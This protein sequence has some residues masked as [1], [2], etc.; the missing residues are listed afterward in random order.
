MTSKH[1]FRG[2]SIAVSAD[3]SVDEQRYLYQKTREFKEAWTHGG[4][5]SPF[6]IEDPQLSV[7]LMFFEDSTRTKES[8]RNAAQFHNVAVNIFDAKNSSIT[9]SES[10]VDTIKMLFG[11]SQRSIFILRT[12]MEGVCRALQEELGRYAE[13]IGREA[14]VFINGGD[15]RHEHP[16]QEYLDEFTFLE[17]RQWDDSHIHLALIGDLLHGRT[18]HSKVDGLKAF[19]EVK[20]DLVAPLELALP[21]YYEKRMKANGFEVEKYESLDKYMAS[22]KLSDCWYF[23]RLQLERMGE[24]ILKKEFQLRKAVTFDQKWTKL[25]QDGTRF[26]H[27]LPRHRE[28]SV[29][30][31]FLDR[32]PLNGWDGQSINGYFTRTIELAICA[33]WLGSDFSGRGLPEETRDESFIHEEPVTRITQVQ[34]RFKVG[35]KPVD[36]GVVIDHIAKGYSPEEIWHRIDKI[37][38]ILNLNCGS[39][40]GVF[41]SEQSDK[42]FKGIISLPDVMRIEKYD[43]KKLAA[44][45]PGCTVNIISKQSVKEKYRL[46]MPPQIFKF[47]EISCKNPECVTFPAA[48]QHVPPFFYNSGEK[49]FTCR[50]CGKDHEYREIWDI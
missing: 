44:V 43:L 47:E 46:S 20:V 18:V 50:Y 30:P 4:D 15:G 11:Y 6:R 5:L 29:I 39:S 31:T 10:I 32:T 49:I 8:F 13:Q 36:N 27:P 34:D 7:Y 24:E 2:R 1:P 23:T 14:P 35:I 33:G 21:D 41:H 45:S 17:Q 16:T 9:K 19:K 25:I 28:K 3:L 40:H 26:Y 12:R 38:R 22:G 37:R 48:C 42:T